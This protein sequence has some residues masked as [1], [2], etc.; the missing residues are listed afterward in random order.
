MWYRRLSLGAGDTVKVRVWC[1][2]LSVSSTPG[3]GEG[4]VGRTEGAEPRKGTERMRR[5]GQKLGAKGK[6]RTP[7]EGNG[8]K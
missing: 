5:K 8:E 6:Q 7:G 1:G 2:S 3:V 4:G